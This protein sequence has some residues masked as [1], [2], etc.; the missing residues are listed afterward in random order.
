MNN[1]DHFTIDLGQITYG[2]ATTMTGDGPFQF[3]LFQMT[4]GKWANMTVDVELPG[5]A[6]VVPYTYSP[7]SPANAVQWAVPLEVALSIDDVWRCVVS[8]D[9]PNAG[10]FTKYPQVFAWLMSKKERDSWIKRSHPLIMTRTDLPEIDREWGL[11]ELAISTRAAP[12]KILG[13][14]ATKGHLGIGADADVSVYNV[15]PSST[16]L[17]EEP[18]QIIKAFSRSHL[19][20]LAGEVVAK[21]GRI[22]ST[23]HGRVFSSCPTFDTTRWSMVEAEMERMVSH[24][25]SH[26]FANYPVPARYRVQ[27]ESVV[28]IEESGAT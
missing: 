6:G 12:A 3:N 10:P 28:R 15:D 14:Q 2:P 18:K 16:Q 8:T 7:K 5:G 4:Q 9:H 11:T 22:I 25:Y 1:N 27:L 21:N 17:S 24:W 23:P 13:M 20:V 26:S 19:T